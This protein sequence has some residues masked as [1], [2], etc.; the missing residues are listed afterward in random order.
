MTRTL[1]DSPL[2]QQFDLVHHD[3][4]DR[5]DTSNIGQLD[6]R[7]VW[8]A[9]VHGVS[10]ATTLI[11]KRPDI[12]YI[13]VA[14]NTLGFL[15]DA[16][17]LG[18]TLLRGVPLVVHLHGGGFAEFAR[19]APGPVRSL[20]RALLA[21]ADRVI[22]LG[23]ALTGMLAGIVA[24]ERVV[25]VPNCVPEI[26]DDASRVGRVGTMRVLF[27]GNLIPSKGYV[28]LLAAVQTL[29]DEGV[30]IAA[31]FAGE[32]VDARV[33]ARALASV[34]HPDRIRFV[35]PVD[36][37]AKAALLRESDALALPSYYDNEAHPLV[38]LEAM[39]AGLAVVATHHVAIPEIVV[40]GETGLLVQRRDVDALTHALRVLAG[41]PAARRRMGAAA[42][43]RYLERF[44]VA[45]WAARMGRIFEDVA[46]GAGP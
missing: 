41:D 37:P 2:A 32:V 44:T 42:R 29:L 14:Q 1:L 21:R 38:L 12:V 31:T 34:R 18:P 36:K 39:A 4:S 6:G 17:F 19:S 22:V 15:R 43:A 10:F 5:R 3:I 8:L 23:D 25:V 13:P 33:H 40:D 35:G 28:E 27:L 20:L 9:G 30:D 11:R 16:L 45:R 24:H 7:N 26:A 46:L